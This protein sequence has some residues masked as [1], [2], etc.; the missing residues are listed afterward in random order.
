MHLLGMH[1]L[2][3][4][5]AVTG[6]CECLG[7]VGTLVG[8]SACVLVYVKFEVLVA[9]ERLVAERTGMWPQIR[10]GYTVGT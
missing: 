7:A 5:E 10:V 1:P 3:M 9:F 8:S 2:T 4:G 6:A